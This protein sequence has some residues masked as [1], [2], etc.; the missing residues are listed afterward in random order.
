M[1]LVKAIRRYSPYITINSYYDSQF[2]DTN[3]DPYSWYDAR[4]N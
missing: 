4:I 3:S 2:A 1:N